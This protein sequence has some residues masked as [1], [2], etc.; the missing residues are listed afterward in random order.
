VGI[1]LSMIHLRRWFYLAG[2]LLGLLGILV[3]WPSRTMG[4]TLV[5]VA[6]ALILIQLPILLIG[7]Y[8]T[9]RHRQSS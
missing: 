3:P 8:H 9:R 6:I 2:F 7:R 4:R 5:Y 1:L